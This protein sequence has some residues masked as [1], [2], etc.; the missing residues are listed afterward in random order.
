MFLRSPKWWG[1]IRLAK[2][3]GMRW[4][5][6]RNLQEVWV[7]RTF[8]NRSFSRLSLNTAH[9]LKL[10]SGRIENACGGSAAAPK[11]FSEAQGLAGVRQGWEK[12][13][14]AF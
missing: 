4:G 6:R 8:G 5:C 2:H 14:G 12:H 7:S 9:L 1:V 3:G 10:G 13:C 11:L